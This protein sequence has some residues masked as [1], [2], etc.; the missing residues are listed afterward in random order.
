MIIINVKVYLAEYFNKG[1]VTEQKASA[2]DVA[3]TMKY[4]KN[5]A[6]SRYSPFFSRQSYLQSSQ[7]P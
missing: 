4:K 5:S 7:Q 6:G 2:K 1:E 3:D